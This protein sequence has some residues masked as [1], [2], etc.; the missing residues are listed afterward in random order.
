MEL[1][2][3]IPDKIDQNSTIYSTILWCG[4]T[5]NGSNRC[6]SAMLYSSQRIHS[7]GRLIVFEE[8]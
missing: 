3:T 2:K 5:L 4:Q 7:G 1:L 6:I 8:D